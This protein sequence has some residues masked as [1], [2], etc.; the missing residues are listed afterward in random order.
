VTGRERECREHVDRAVEVSRELG[1]DEHADWQA[2][3][4]LGLLELGLGHPA[5][6]VRHLEAGVCD[7]RGALIPGV[8][9]GHGDLIEA[10][11]RSGDAERARA[12]LAEW[13]PRVRVVE[14]G[15]ALAVCA[16]CAGLLAEDDRLDEHFEEA[17]RRHDESPVPFDTARTQLAYGERLRRAHRRVDA[18]GH[19]RK[20]LASFDRLGARPWA[21]RA[22][23]ELAA[24][25]ERLR[26]R[27]PYAAEELTAQELQ[28]AL[29]VAGGATNREA[30]AQLFVSPKTIEA[31]LGSI[32]RKLG[33]RSRTELAGRFASE[34]PA[35]A[36]A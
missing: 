17:L 32:Y 24:S 23:A 18:R 13:E 5:D 22:R 9:R 14:R 21:E 3:V 12:A 11:A 19:L 27:D 15:W 35:P 31:H 2:A 6:A 28:V 26:K 25:G 20:A 16:R 34:S 8:A 30:A 29:V 1:L 7:E 36:P 10:Y 4:A 33:V